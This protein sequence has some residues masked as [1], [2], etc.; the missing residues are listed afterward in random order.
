M[1]TTRKR[2]SVVAKLQEAKTSRDVF[3]ALFKLVGLW[4]EYGMA[5]ETGSV[6]RVVLFTN[7]FN[8]DVIRLLQHV[9]NISSVMSELREIR[10]VQTRISEEG[11]LELRRLMPSVKI[12]RVSEATWMRCPE[13]GDPRF[14]LEKQEMDYPRPVAQSSDTSVTDDLIR[15]F[16]K[17]PQTPPLTDGGR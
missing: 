14:D 9:S 11:E 5:P 16:G 15:R 8:D 7:G 10:L 6:R 13:S 17:V 4:P 3:R 2:D 1:S 12:V